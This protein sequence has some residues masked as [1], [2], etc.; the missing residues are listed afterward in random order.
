MPNL[1]RT[2]W[3]LD[4]DKIRQALRDEMGIRGATQVQV[5]EECG[6]LGTGV[7]RFLVQR[8]TL[9]GDALVS[10]IKWIGGDVNRFIVRRGRYVRHTDTY[11]QRQLR[12]A[13]AFL[14]H[15]GVAL[16]PGESPVDALMELV[17]KAKEDTDA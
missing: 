4:T 13:S 9:H 11:E 12:K 16:K 7:S 17:A 5:G 1:R 8:Q 3:F 14:A 10:V 6:I 15:Q 2:T